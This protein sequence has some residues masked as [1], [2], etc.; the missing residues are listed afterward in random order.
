MSKFF[1]PDQFVNATRAR[2]TGFLGRK[3]TSSTSESK[4][5][6]AK[7]SMPW[8]VESTKGDAARDEFKYQYH[9]QNDPRNPPKDAPSAL[10]TVVVPNVNLPKVIPPP[11]SLRLTLG[12]V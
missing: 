2:L 11:Y 6:I 4:V 8:Q 5:T 9:P 3:P 7:G 10:H 12:K 1:Q